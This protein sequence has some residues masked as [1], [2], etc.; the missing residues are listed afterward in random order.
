[1]GAILGAILIACGTAFLFMANYQ[2]W[3]LQ[4][5]LNEY[6]REDQKF[7]PLFWH[8]G[9]HQKLRQLQKQM[10]PTSSRLKRS[11]RF[12]IPGGCLFCS[13]VIVLLT[14]YR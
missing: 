4:F 13:G 9:T 11:W 3:Q 6:L 10:L 5:E 1:M 8:F 14:S 2:I 12:A 7:E